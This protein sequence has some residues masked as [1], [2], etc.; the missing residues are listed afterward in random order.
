MVLA[1]TNTPWQLDD[2][3][4]RR[5]EKRLYIP[6][7]D[8]EARF[9]LFNILLRKIP[10]SSNVDCNDLAMKTSGYSGSDVKV[11]CKEAAM[12]PMRRLL[13]VLNVEEMM[14]LK[15]NGELIVPK[16]FYFIF[17]IYF[18]FV[19]LFVL[20]YKILRLLLYLFL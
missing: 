8:E 16:V 4:L 6:L 12:M 9:E 18:F 3:L 17:F 13:R 19:I 5:L 20:F 1:T 2:A 7:P 15:K 10:V 11:V 14:E